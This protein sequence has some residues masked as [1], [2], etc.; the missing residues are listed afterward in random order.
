MMKQK[1]SD[2]ME[3]PKTEP[4]LFMRDV[5]KTY[6]SGEI[7]TPV[8]KGIGLEAFPG[9]FIVL[10]GVSGSGKTTL[11]NIA[12]ALDEADHG[13]V[14]LDGV[15]LTGL[16]RKETIEIRRTKIGFVFQFYN[17]MPTL[18]ALENVALGLELLRLDKREVDNRSMDYLRRVGM[19]HLAH[20]YP[21][22]LSGGE[23]QRV[24]IARSLAK[25]PRLI[26]ADEPTGNLDEHT[27][28]DVIREMKELNRMT[29]TTFVVA[30]H[31]A[32]LAREADRVFQLHEGLLD[33]R[34][35][36]P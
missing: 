21:G 1:T 7:D 34:V 23:Q 35:A 11:L 16:S 18:T 30:S 10:F 36:R 26:L 4:V 5:G 29:E 2:K 28:A 3:R 13:T 20:K 9:E 22:Q 6:R 19:Q 12:G 24:A 31:N 33:D 15:E 25:E 27:A 14:R 32:Q 17:L 8:L